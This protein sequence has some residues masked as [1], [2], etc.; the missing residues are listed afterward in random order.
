MLR[1][2]V[3]GEPRGKGRPRIG[4]LANGRPIAFTDAKTVSYE[5]LVRYAAKEAM[6]AAGL[7]MFPAG[8]PLTIR[9]L[10]SFTVPASKSKAWQRAALAG[11]HRPTKKPDPDNVLKVIDALNGV[12]WHDD[13]QVV[14]VSIS[15][16]YAAE[17]GLVIEVRPL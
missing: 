6:V 12:V 13:V 7:T 2:E 8:V 16:V 4:R 15:K 10:A 5:N 1:I 9:M 11:G 17:P 3:P 14:E